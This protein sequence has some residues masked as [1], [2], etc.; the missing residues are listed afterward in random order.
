MAEHLVT[1]QPHS[2]VP[3]QFED[4]FQQK[5]AVTLGMWTFLATEVLFFGA[6]FTGYTI[7]RHQYPNAFRQGS[8]DLKWYMG[9]VN[10]AVLLLSSFFMAMAVH[11]AAIGSNSKIIRY[12]I[13]TII[14]GCLFLAIKGTEYYIEYCE[15][16]V[17]GSNFW[18]HKPSEEQVGPVVRG[19]DKFEEWFKTKVSKPEQEADQRQQDEQLFMLFY[20]IMTAI[21]ATHM[22]IGICI[23]LVLVAMAKRGVFSEKYHNPVE[24]FGLYWH[25]V[26][27]VWVF[28]FPTLYL[29]R[30]P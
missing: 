27:I 8:L 12:L 4:R 25:F 6:L 2:L 20:F 29:L 23:M 24:M 30:Q 26:D 28:L 11:A 21:H 16:L 9:G 17:P 3:E 15:H 7:Y 19:F 22:I 13:I 18:L 10:T 14:V 1:E 5:E